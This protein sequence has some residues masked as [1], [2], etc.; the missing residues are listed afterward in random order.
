MQKPKYNEARPKFTGSYKKKSVYDGV[1]NIGEKHRRF[2][3]S[4]RQKAKSRTLELCLQK[5]PIDQESSY[6]V[7]CQ[8]HDIVQMKA[9]KYRTYTKDFVKNITV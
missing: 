6:N 2:C 8:S 9:I 4:E 1:V 7:P 3:L 5:K